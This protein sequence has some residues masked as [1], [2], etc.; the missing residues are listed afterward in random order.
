MATSKISLPPLPWTPQTIFSVPT[1]RGGPHHNHCGHDGNNDVDDGDHDVDD[2]N[3]DDGN[4]DDVDGND[5]DDVD[6]DGEDNEAKCDQVCGGGCRET[7][8][9][10]QRHQEQQEAL[11]PTLNLYPDP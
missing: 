2:D 4:G 3:D 1:A 5:D 11:V 6:G 10:M 7:H 8:S 9:Q